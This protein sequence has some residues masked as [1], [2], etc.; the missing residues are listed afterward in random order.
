[1]SS[2]RHITSPD[3]LDLNHPI[4]GDKMNTTI[5]PTN[6]ASQSTSAHLDVNG[7]RIPVTLRRWKSGEILVKHDMGRI[8]EET[9]LPMSQE[10]Q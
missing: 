9:H 6:C 10:V 5:E 8:F 3:S 7:F 4:L 1:M 2:T